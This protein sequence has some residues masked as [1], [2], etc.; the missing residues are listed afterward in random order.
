MSRVVRCLLVLGFVL[1]ITATPAQAGSTRREEALLAA[2]WTTVLETPSSE[3]PFGSGGQ[4]FACIDLGRAVAPFAP[5]AADSC[6][7]RVG[8]QLFI[9]GFSVECSTFEG[10]GTTEAALRQCAREGDLQSAPTVTIDGRPATVEEVE[11]PLL[12]ITLPPDNIFGLPGGT[13]GLSVGHGWVVLQHPLRP[14]RHEIRIGA[15]VTTEI[16]VTR[17][18]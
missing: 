7:V 13:Q 9:V 8:T 16:I 11:S 17:G 10:N 6:T 5:V 2:L 14:G 1:G 18:R 4:A 12:H 3:N 15:G